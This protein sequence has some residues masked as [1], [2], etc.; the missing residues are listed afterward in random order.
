MVH[1]G[2]KELII[3]SQDTTRYGMDLYRRK[4]MLIELL[5]KIDQVPGDFTY[6]LLYLYPDIMTK[7]HLHHMKDLKKFIPYFDVPLQHISSTV[8]KRMGRFYEERSINTFLDT[9][10]KYF[11]VRF[12]RTNLIIGF[13]GETKED[14]MKLKKFVQKMDFDNIALFEY[15]DE[16]FA[17][18]SKLDKKV[19]DV[20]IRKRFL[21]MEKLVDQ[22]FDKKAKARKGKEDVGYVMN[23]KKD[24]LVVRPR[25]HAPEIDSYD[26]IPM[27]NVIA[28]FEK[29]KTI[30][31]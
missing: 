21:E 2:I 16:P 20:E 9:I 25:L 17:T 1:A 10:K 15:H 19:P 14:F 28:M 5:K 29:K 23:I 22:L 26:E 27:K 7:E 30:H 13:P 31:I 8:L 12:I 6:R 4:P 11:P 18:S 24:K 3:I